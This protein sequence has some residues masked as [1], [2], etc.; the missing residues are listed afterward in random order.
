MN[1]SAT[2]A[3]A[4]PKCRT[5]NELPPGFSGTFRCKKC[6]G[7]VRVGAAGMSEQQKKVAAARDAGDSRTAQR[8]IIIFAVVGVLLAIVLLNSKSPPTPI[9]DP[10]SPRRESSRGAARNDVPDPPP[11]KELPKSTQPESLAKK[12]AVALANDD[13]AT[14]DQMFDYARYYS[15]VAR[16]NHWDDA[17]KYENKSPDE[18]K[19][20]RDE[21]RELLL[22]ADRSRH[23]KEFV[24][25]KIK[26]LAEDLFSNKDQG[27]DYGTFTFDVRNET[28][29]TAFLM[30]VSVGL[31][32]GFDAEKDAENPAAWGVYEV[33]DQWLITTVE[34]PRKDRGFKDAVEDRRKEE[35][36]ATKTKGPPE[37]AP[38][39][40][41]PMP[42]TSPAQVTAF[43]DAVRVLVDNS[44]GAQDVRKA[45]TL[46]RDAGKP[47]IPFLLNGL[48]GKDHRENE[49]DRIASGVIVRELIEITGVQINYGPQNTG[50]R[51]LGGIMAMTPD[52]REQAV[53]R[54]FGWW[55][56]RGPKWTKKLE[57]PEPEEE[58]TPPK[59]PTPPKKP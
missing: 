12:F 35:V 30:R 2:R 49:Q 38:A 42:G 56:V 43:K 14:I 6:K 7:G 50:E 29:K 57:A 15:A 59:P 23:L 55:K 9:P 33:A 32:D 45:K 3:V 40:L 31:R 34:R 52:E 48:V 27:N 25:P 18:Q 13:R 21:A 16:R 54:W 46:L 36:V 19:A 28:G 17:R 51:G 20:Y 24:A 44:A 10:A 22:T 11:R 26:A 47:A 39:E 5:Q 8:A 58:E 37:E 4:C 1:D 53:R 41:A